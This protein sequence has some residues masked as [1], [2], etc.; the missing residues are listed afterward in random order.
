QQPRLRDGGREAV[1][2]TGPGARPVL[3]RGDGRTEPDRLAPRVAGNARARYRRAVDVAVLLPR[4]RNDPRYL[5]DVLRRPADDQH[6]G[7]WRVLSPNPGHA[8]RADLQ[9]LPGLPG[10]TGRVRGD[11]DGEPDLGGPH[12]GRGRGDARG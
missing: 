8:G 6:D 7:D 9:L 4:T 2:R 11:S 5:R 1:R 3:A 10:A 12:Q